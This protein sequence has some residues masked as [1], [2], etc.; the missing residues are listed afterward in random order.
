[1][2]GVF[3]TLFIR[4]V[5]P[6][7]GNARA[8]VE[9]WEICRLFNTDQGCLGL[10]AGPG[11]SRLW[12][13]T[14]HPFYHFL[15]CQQRR[16]RAGFTRPGRVVDVLHRSAGDI[17]LGR[18]Y[19]H[20]HGRLEPGAKTGQKGV[21]E[22]CFHHSVAAPVVWNMVDWVG[23]SRTTRPASS[24]TTRSAE[25]IVSERWATMMRVTS[26]ARTASFTCCSHF[27]SR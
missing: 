6:S 25:A 23:W 12:V 5:V 3:P 20:C 2:P 22:S 9:S 16:Y 21:D 10:G 13:V 1:M 8:T 7:T 15:Q 24:I 19:I 18:K 26:S 17:T 14:K 27:T 11:L 4:G